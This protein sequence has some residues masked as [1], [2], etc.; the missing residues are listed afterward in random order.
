MMGTS[1]LSMPWAMERAGMIP[2]IVLL[3]GATLLSFYTAY[4][5]LEVFEAH[6]KSQ[7]QVYHL[8]K[9]CDILQRILD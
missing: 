3:L 5:I 1:L 6:R 9:L 7:L 4:R 8:M 2:A